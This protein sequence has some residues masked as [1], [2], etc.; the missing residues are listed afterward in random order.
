MNA[1]LI[2]ASIIGQIIDYF[3]LLTYLINGIIFARCPITLCSE[4]ELLGYVFCDGLCEKGFHIACS[5]SKDKKIPLFAVQFIKLQRLRVENQMEEIRRV[6]REHRLA[7][8]QANALKFLQ[9]AEEQERERIR[10]EEVNDAIAIEDAENRVQDDDEDD[11][12]EEFLMSEHKKMEEIKKTERNMCEMPLL[13]FMANRFKTSP[14]EASLLV[15]A[16]L[17]DLKFATPED[18]SKLVDRGKVE[19]AKE[20]V[21]KVQ[22]AKRDE[23]LLQPGPKG[24]YLDSRHDKCLAKKNIG[25]SISVTKK[26]PEEDHYSVVFHP[27][28]KF[29]DCTFHITVPKNPPEG[30]NKAQYVADLILRKCHE[31]NLN[32]DE[33]VMCGGDS[34]AT[35]TGVGD[36]GGIFMWMER[37]LEKN[38]MWS[39]CSIHILELTPKNLF[40]SLDGPTASGTVYTG[41]IGKVLREDVMKLQIDPNFV[42][43]PQYYIPVLPDEVV[44]ELSS[45]QL[46][47]YH[48]AH[49]VR[50]GNI[51]DEFEKYAI[52]PLNKARWNTHWS[53]IFRLYISKRDTLVPNLSP[54]DEENLKLMVHFLLSCYLPAWFQIRLNQHYLDAPTVFLNLMTNLQD[55]PQVVKSSVEKTLQTGAYALHPDPLLQRMLCGDDKEDRRFAIK[56][57]IKNR[58]RAGHPNIGNLNPMTSPRRVNPKL[59]FDA[60]PLTF[61]NVIDWNDGVFRE[62]PLT[63]KISSQNLWS[64]LD[65]K[66]E[67]PANFP[68]HTQ[69]VERMIKRVTEAG[70]HVASEDKR[71]GVILA[72][73][74]ACRMLPVYNSKKDLAKLT[75]YADTYKKKPRN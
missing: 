2:Q 52:G 50:T 8:E 72:Q 61:Q 70:L 22:Q 45:D 59:N 49:M 3:L 17:V 64:F 60:R 4:Q 74:E 26:N 33:I 30:V 21:Q 41:S 1:T 13:G 10:N 71:D 12:D 62:P 34:T 18:C 57:T 69:S 75:D 67:F 16:A 15:S 5:C 36:L 20:K 14:R 11:D 28:E 42:R 63:C 65:T 51:I 39:V 46:Y 27:E 25:G 35:N 44:S 24:L 54:A 19:R 47:L 7:E 31:K 6:S 48:I 29:P 23:A 37:F 9:Q 56:A 32:M 58:E 66:M 38:L 55:Q 53:R 73:L 43:L 68:N 40:I